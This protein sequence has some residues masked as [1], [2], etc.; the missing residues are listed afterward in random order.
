MNVE[1]S[2]VLP[3]HRVDD[4]LHQALDSV[5]A[6]SFRD[7]ELI[8]VADGDAKEEI[9]ILSERY[10]A[11]ARVKFVLNLGLGLVDGLNTGIEKARGKYIARMDSDDVCAPGRFAEQIAVLRAKPFVAVVGT[12]V[13][14]VCQHSSVL[15]VSRYPATVSNGVFSKP[16][17]PQ[18]AHPAAM[19]RKLQWN[20][21][22]A[23]RKLFLHVE[24][25]DF[26]N[27]LLEL[28][29]I[30]NLPTV[31]LSY[32][33]H[34]G[35]ISSTNA[36]TQISE[37]YRADIFDCLGIVPDSESWIPAQ[38]SKSSAADSLQWKCGNVFSAMRRAPFRKK[39]RA[40]QI[41]GY[42]VARDAA[43][44]FAA[45]GGVRG[46]FSSRLSKSDPTW[47]AISRLLEF[48]LA[49]S[50]FL[51]EVAIQKRQTFGPILGNCRR[52]AE[53]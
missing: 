6:S 17:L 40:R 50:K 10:S 24:D 11:D 21:V 51:A 28:G 19:F 7:F 45:K 49:T 1:L 13:Q 23:Y 36:N 39:M 31:G 29:K 37:A 53:G 44:L 33:V 46:L 34:S 22:G 4:F 2:V 38:S 14:Y 12:Q 35:Q 48:P 43:S 41:I 9:A 47:V 30:E 16:V 32:R 15:G 26:W 20:Q 52:C 8:A 5:L 18:I 3:F 25:L 27:R 42:F